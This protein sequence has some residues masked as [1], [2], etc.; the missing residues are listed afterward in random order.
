M[1]EWAERAVNA[2]RRLG[3]AP[4]TAAAPRR[5]RARG[6]DDGGG[7][8][9]RSARRRRR[10]WSSRCRT[11]SSPAAS[12]PRAGS[13]AELYLDRYAEGDAHATAHWPWRV[14][15]GRGSSSSSSSRSWA[16]CGASAASWPRPAELLDGGIEA[17][18]LLGNTHALVWNLSAARLAALRTGTSSSRSPPLRRASTSARISTRASTAEAAAD[19]AAALLETGQPERAVELLLGSAGGEELVLIAGSPRARYLEL[20]T[21]CWLALDRHAEAKTRRRRARGL[22]LGRP[23]PDGGR[24]GRSSGGGRRLPRRRRRRAAERRSRRPPPPTRSARRSRQRCRARSRAA[25]S[26]RPARATVPSPSCSARPRLRRL[27]RAA[28]PRRGGARAAQAR[29]S[30]P[31]PHAPGKADATGL[32]SLTERELQVARLVV[33]RKTNPEIAAELFLSQ[34]TVETHLRNIFPR[35]CTGPPRAPRGGG[36]EP[37][38]PGSGASPPPP[39]A[40]AALGGGRSPRLLGGGES[41]GESDPDEPTAPLDR[42]AGDEHGVDVGGIREDDDGP[43]GSTIGAVLIAFVCRRTMS[44]C[45]PG[46]SDPTLSSRPHARAPSIVANSSTSV[47]DRLGSNGSSGESVNSPIRS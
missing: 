13:P 27:R 6:F 34:K 18:R 21:R 25:R 15:P 29:P 47:Y 5:A 3:D 45:L 2:A 20:L 31:P 46:V 43:H 28:L 17:A 16:G 35:P 19:L 24:L 32:E 38:K 8:A 44:A 1:H 4:L 30:R 12:T 22:G 23:A 14:R 33:D 36:G 10:R 11:T 40:G 39:A 7:R 9:S 26:P 42:L 41:G 37:R